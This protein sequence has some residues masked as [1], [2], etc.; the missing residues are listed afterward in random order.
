MAALFL[1]RNSKPTAAPPEAVGA[2]SSVRDAHKPSDYFSAERAVALLIIA[3]VALWLRARDLGFTT[4]YMDE[5]IYVVYGRMFLSRHFEAPLD[6]PLRWSFGWYLWPAMAALADRIRGLV[7]VRALGAALGT[8]SV[9]A[10]YG[11]SRRLFDAAVGLGTAALF[12]VLAPAVMASRIATRDA[13]TIFFFTFGL[14]AFASAWQTNQRRHWLA[15]AGCLLA[16]FLCKYIVAIYLPFLCLIALRKGIRGALAFCLPLTGALCTYFLVYR[17]DLTHLILYGRSY[18]SLQTS[19]AQLWDIYVRSRIDLWLIASLALLAWLLRSRRNVTAL[20]WLGAALAF[21]FQWKTRADFDF[22]KH[23]IYPLIFLTP[24]AVRTVL[25]AA[26]RIGRTLER[27]IAFSV[28]G[29]LCL[30][31]VALGTG[32]AIHYDRAVFWP[33]VE[34]PLSYLEGRL[35][36]NTRLLTDDSVFRYYLHPQLS[37]SQIVDPF[38]FQYGQNHGEQA[39]TAAV[40]DGWFDYIVL[41]GGMGGDAQALQRAIH[42]HLQAYA[43]CLEMPDPALRQTTQIYQRAACAQP[44]APDGAPAVDILSPV[45]NSLVEKVSVVSGTVRGAGTGWHVQPEVFTNRWYP[46]AQLP[47]AADGA[48][49]TTVVFGGEG[50]QACYQMLRVR[51]Y[52]ERNHSRAVSVLSNLKTR[53]SCQQN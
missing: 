46:M 34:Q 15:A 18:G 36:S 6:S 11:F 32:K 26:N 2:H 24:L 31:V 43:L 39:Y 23:A 20:L 14:W 42:G 12:A 45:A 50:E 10:L 49:Q 40:E 52:D 25:A 16:A 3:G 44:P 38:Y 29:I 4:A 8:A 13:G 27:Q 19:G 1:G 33:N 17:G 9:V 21:G 30:C 53:G 35:A 37:Q 22:W 7:A 47:L 5:S 41:D 51:L 48:F 28:V